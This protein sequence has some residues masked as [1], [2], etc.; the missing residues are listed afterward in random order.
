MSWEDRVREAAYTSPSG[1][2]R[3][4]AFET[5]S[6]E[7]ELRAKAFE[8]PGV[9]AT[10]VQGNGHGGRRFP[11]RCFFSGDDHDLEAEAFIG[12]LLERGVGRLEHPFYGTHDVVPLGT[13]TRRDDLK[14]AANQTVVEVT[15]AVSLTRVYPTLRPSRSAEV[16]ASLRALDEASALQFQDALDLSTAAARASEESAVRDSLAAASGTLADIAAGVDAVRDAFRDAQDAV[17]LGLDVLI[18]QPLQLAQSIAN[19]VRAPARSDVAIRSR[20]EAYGDFLERIVTAPSARPGDAFLSGVVLPGR[21]RVVSNDFHT[22]VVFA[23][24]G[25]AGSV[26]SVLNHRFPDRPAALAAAETLLGQLDRVVP[27]MEDGFGDLAD[28]DAPASVDTGGT[29]QALQEAVALAAGFLVEISF[30]LLPQRRVVL[31]RPRT[32]I[33]L[34]AEFYGEVDGRLDFILRT[35]DLSGSEILEL[36][37][38]REFVF[39]A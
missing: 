9:D 23:A 15:L 32:I 10:Y 11:L 17:N 30:T 34:A 19:L 36:P 14:D 22:A 37:R 2:R 27:W 4:F 18:G 29:Y 26:E 25:V 28:A 35:N 8:F 38:G 33:D 21:R 12:G 5:V 7:V 39:Y 6:A 16:S 31:D 20:L 3:V 13:V 24:Q 1:T